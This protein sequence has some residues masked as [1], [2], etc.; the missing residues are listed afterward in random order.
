MWNLI[1]EFRIVEN[2]LPFS[3]V[4]FPSPSLNTPVT[5][6][7]PPTLSLVTFPPHT[8]NKP[9]MKDTPRTLSLVTSLSQLASYGGH[10]TNSLAGHLPTSLSQQARTHHQLSCWSPCHLPPSTRRGLATN[11]LAGHLPP[12]F[13][14]SPAGEDMPIAGHF[15]HHSH[16]Y[17]YLTLGTYV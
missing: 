17:T 14:D 12:P 3:Q 6:D 1:D 16:Y 15:P 8:L 4:T 7:K 10:A 2:V 5:E 9:A 11:S 13:F